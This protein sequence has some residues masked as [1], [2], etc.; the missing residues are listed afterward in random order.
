MGRT[1]P[2]YLRRLRSFLKA[3]IKANKTSEDKFHPPVA[4]CYGS[5]KWIDSNRIIGAGI[6]VSSRLG[7]PY[8]EVTGYCIPTLLNFGRIDLTLQ[9]ARWLISVQ[10]GDGSW[11]DASG[12]TPYTFDSGQVLKGLLAVLPRLPEAEGPIRRGCEWMLTQV[13]PDGRIT[14]PDKGNWV[15]PAGKEVSENIHL[16]VLE[17][18]R[19]AGTLFNEPRYMEATERAL[20]YYLAQPALVRF[21]TLSH[22]HAYVI[23]AL[24]DLGHPEAAAKGME[25]VE[26]LQKKDG[27]IP[28]YPDV[29]WICS[30][31]MAQ[32]ATIWYKLGKREPAQKAL[33]YLSRIQNHSGGFFGSYGRAANYFPGE[34]VSWAVKFALDAYYWHI[35]TAFDADVSLYPD[36]VDEDDG[37]LQAVVKCLGDL[38]GLSVLDAGCGK[39]RFARALIARYPSAEMWGVDVSDAML[40]H[41]PPGIR[42]KQGSLLNLPFSDSSF[43]RVYC[44]EA[45]E[46]AIDPSAAVSELCRV[47]KP[48]GRIVIVDKNIQRQGA[49]ETEA[50]EQWFEQNE[51]KILLGRYC[52][53]VRSEFIAYGEKLG[54]D[55]LFIVWQGTR[56]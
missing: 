56:T 4:L 43:D 39:G 14:T 3:G 24:V 44:V 51:I 5:L 2:G 32:Y 20:A 31:G 55:G 1:P 11:S 12:R 37:R 6:P 21:N 16:Y 18:L 23:E 45:L 25:E 9:F 36:T 50:W 47:A 30:T 8:P 29:S 38:S 13:K 7:E 52:R 34:E 53:D 15:L 46:H 48:G 28:A 33:G 17:A 42:T 49:L 35:R 41:V 19:D 26:H 27:S 10:N 54:P 22:F 40:L